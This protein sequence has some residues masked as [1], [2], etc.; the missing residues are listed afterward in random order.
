MKKH[1]LLL[2]LFTFSFSVSSFTQ[3]FNVTKGHIV[4]TNGDTLR[5]ML[6]DRTNI[7]REVA[8]QV[9]GESDFTNYTID[10]VRSVF[11]DDGYYFTPVPSENRFLLCLAEGPMSLYKY[12]DYYLVQ[13]K[14]GKP[15]K[16]ERLYP[17]EAKDRELKEDNRYKGLL[18]ALLA[19]CAKAQ[20]KVDEVPFNDRRLTDLVESYN[21]CIDPTQRSKTY[22]TSSK[23]RIRKGVRAG[24]AFNKSR[25]NDRDDGTINS[26]RTVDLSPSTTFT[27]GIWAN[28]S[29]REKIS[30]QTE[31][32]YMRK[33]G[34]YSG[35]ISG[36][37][38][39]AYDFDQSWL[40]VP[41]CLHLTLPLTKFRPFLYAGPQIG[42]ALK[43]KGSINF[44]NY[45]TVVEPRTFDLGYR[46]GA[47]L[48]FRFN[49]KNSVFLEYIYESTYVA[50]KITSPNGNTK[51][52]THHV[53]A[54]FAF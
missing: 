23:I 46:G 3:V 10:Q 18:K 4:L 14:G 19:D 26:R 32:L 33:A 40:Q 24:V 39:I 31:L 1:V 52:F 16:L 43:S 21:H 29:Y 34:T 54:R 53:S 47:G 30:I 50:N 2:L 11:Y 44:L 35:K 28:F 13:K 36:I 15:V 20:K 5:G 38:D 45:V 7:G 6:K 12:Q 27:G 41:F 17:S 49:A 8:I 22:R 48:E 25:Y 42:F 9:A 37:Y 51:N